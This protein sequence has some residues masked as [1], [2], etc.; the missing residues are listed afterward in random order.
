MNRLRTAFY[1]AIL[2]C[3][4]TVMAMSCA[5]TATAEPVTA[6][7]SWTAPTE[8]VDGTPLAETDLAGYRIYWV[9]DFEL[10][11]QGDYISVTGATA[12]TWTLDLPT[13]AQPYKVHFAAAA[14]DTK[15]RASALSNIVTA[16]FLVESTASPRAPTSLQFEFNCAAGC[17]ITP[18]K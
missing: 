1:A 12:R 17:V 16:E 13:R 18:V 6:Q 15:G 4:L 2:L 9:V 3:C 11:P 10:D 8:R 5:N 7:L 14:V